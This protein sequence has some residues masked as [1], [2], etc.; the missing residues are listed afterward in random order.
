MLHCDT[1]YVSEVIVINKTSASIE[2]DICH[3]WYFLD[4]GFKFQRYSFNRCY[5]ALIVSVN[6]NG[7]AILNINGADYHFIIGSIRK[8]D[9][10][11]LLKDADLTEKRSIIK[12][13]I[14]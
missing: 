7:T 12:I 13:K 4:K 14:L 6:L 1:V 10:V 5:N 9:A 8:R 11:N 3:Y 2:C